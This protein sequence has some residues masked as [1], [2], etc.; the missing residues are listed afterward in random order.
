MKEFVRLIIKK[1]DK[2]L[3]IKEVKG[4]WYDAWNFPGGK[5][6]MG[7]TADVAA[8]RELK[9]EMNLTAG[10][11]SLLYETTISF[12]NEPWRGLYFVC[13]E[14][15][16]NTLTIME[17]TKCNGYCFFDLNELKTIP[18]GIPDDVIAMLEQNDK[19]IQ[20]I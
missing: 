8:L 17:P 6:D 4:D 19:A 12:N 5:V 13:S 20:S 16:L 9:E 15:H 2:Y 1:A 11:L 7:E 14:C 10:T 3:L 18:L